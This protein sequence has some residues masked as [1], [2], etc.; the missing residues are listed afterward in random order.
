MMTIDTDQVERNKTSTGAVSAIVP[1]A[2]RLLVPRY[3]AFE[4]G[5]SVRV[6]PQCVARLATALRL[7]PPQ[8]MTLSQL[9]FPEMYRLLKQ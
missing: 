6:S 5:R 4:S 9:A 1:H 8:Q 3:R 2:Q 7:T